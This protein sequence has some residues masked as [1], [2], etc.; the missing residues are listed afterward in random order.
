ML[1]QITSTIF[2]TLGIINYSIGQD[3][4]FSQYN[5][6]PQF[7]N[8]AMTGFH[9]GIARAGLV[10]RNQWMNVGGVQGTFHTGGLNL[11]LALLKN[12]LRTDYFGL[13]LS[14]IY[15]K[16]G[17]NVFQTTG[18]ALNFAY[19]KGFGSKVNQSIALGFGA[20]LQYRNFQ[21]NQQKFSDDIPE[22]IGTTSTL[23]DMS[24]GIRYHCYVTDKAHVYFGFAYNHL[25]Q[26]KDQ[27]TPNSP[28]RLDTKY[29]AHAGAEVK[30]NN[31]WGL[32][33][34]ALFMFQKNTW[35][36]NFGMMGQIAIGNSYDNFNYFG[37]GLNSRI[38]QTVVD[39][40]IPNAKL[41][42]KG[43]NLNLAYDINVSGLKTGSKG[44]GAIEV[45]ISCI[46]SKDRKF[47]GNRS[48]NP[49]F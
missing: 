17:L 13:G 44:F 5:L 24:I 9:N 38:N 21:R 48:P 40:V 30:F 7:L 10:Y 49:D 43:F 11:D 15:D 35:Q 6:L 14:A 8:P 1:R 25:L 26:S 29:V 23:F 2:L 39:A 4:Q 36:L 34:N 22:N 28:S 45:G 37:I 31:K 12:K 42:F 41:D 33:P 16:N 3:A 19:S 47:R 18:A 32:E 27:R 46:I 20:D